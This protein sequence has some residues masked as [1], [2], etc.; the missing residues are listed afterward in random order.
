MD[1]GAEGVVPCVIINSL[2][3]DSGLYITTTHYINRNLDDEQIT[4]HF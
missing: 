1:V 3:G 2:I 4:S